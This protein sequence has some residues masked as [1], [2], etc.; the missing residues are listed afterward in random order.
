MLEFIDRIIIL[1]AT[2]VREDPK[3]VPDQPALAICD[4]YAAHRW[5]SVLK[6]LTRNHI[7]QVSI[8][9]GCNGKLQ[10]LDLS[11][12]DLFK[13]KMKEQFSNWYADCVKAA[14]DCSESRDDVN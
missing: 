12:N 6:K 5:E 3:L 4:V 2:S 11:G 8:P 10:P 1:Y 7:H 14:L 9:A 13:S